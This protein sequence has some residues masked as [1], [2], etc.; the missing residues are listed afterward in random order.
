MREKARVTNCQ[1]V[2]S[3][4]PIYSRS[5]RSK[6]LIIP[7]IIESILTILVDAFDHLM[8]NHRFL[9][10]RYSETSFLPEWSN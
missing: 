7:K 1:K 8:L 6:S 3:A 4:G 10:G 2:Q 9:G 5:Q